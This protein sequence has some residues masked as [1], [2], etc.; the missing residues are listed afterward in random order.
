MPKYSVIIPVYNAEKTLRRCVDSLLDQN[1]S[2]MELILVNDG[3]PD[4]SLAICRDYQVRDARVRVIDKPNGGVSTARNAGLDVATGEYVL[5][6]DSDDYVSEDYFQE[7]DRLSAEFEYDCVLFSLAMQNGNRTTYRILDSFCA[8]DV[9]IATPKFCEA[10]YKKFLTSPIN[11]RYTRALIE[12]VNVRFP[13]HL[14]V[15]EDKIFSLRYILQCKTCVISSKVL[16][17]VDISDQNSLS[18]KPR[19]DLAEQLQMLSQLTRET[20]RAADIPE[21]HRQQ[22]TEAENLI[23]LREVYSEAKRMH[24][25]RK[26]FRFRR[27]VI[28]N[29]CKDFNRSGMVLP[30]NVFATALTIPVKLTMITLIDGFGK[31]L[32][33]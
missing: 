2:D 4:G 9:E 22:Y 30:R 10:L 29:M 8:K 21:H 15:G 14:Y 28:R 18:R 27:N 19:P 17:T 6:V 1:Y 26:D 16:Y 23:Q 13:E 20:L 11:K 24:L 5:F 33:R 3:S 32:A 7:L 25:A 31:I 12:K